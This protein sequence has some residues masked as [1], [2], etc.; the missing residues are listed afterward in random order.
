[1]NETETAPANKKGNMEMKEM[2]KRIRYNLLCAAVMA[3]TV[4]LAG[5]VADDFGFQSSENNESTFE[6]CISRAEA[7]TRDY[8]GTDF[9]EAEKKVASV[10]LFFY[11]NGATET[12]EAVHYC[13]VVPTMD[14]EAATSNRGKLNVSIPKEIFSGDAKTCRVYAAVNTDETKDKEKLTLGA[15]RDIKATS[16]HFVSKKLNNENDKEAVK[17]FPGFVMFTVAPDGDLVTY[18]EAENKTTGTVIVNKLA[19]K[20]DLFLGFG[21]E[22]DGSN[23]TV[24]APDPNDPSNG[25]KTWKVYDEEKDAIE[26]FIVNGVR[27]VRLGGYNG[28]DF[29][30]AA[31]YF[32]FRQDG[33]RRYAHGFKLSNADDKTTYPNVVEAPFYTY[34]NEWT[35]D[36]LEQHRTHLVLKVNWIPVNGN[37]ETDL[38]ET[39]YMVPLNVSGDSKDRI[40]SNQHYRVK[41]KINTLG[42]QHFGE[43][44]VLD[45]CSYEILPWGT[46]DIDAKL[47]ETRYLEVRQQSEELDPEGNYYTAVMNNVNQITIPYYSSHKVEIESVQI[48]YTDFNKFNT[49]GS[50]QDL[51]YHSAGSQ[52]VE[53]LEPAYFTKTQNELNDNE[54]Q[55][56]YIDDINQ[57]ITVQHYIGISNQNGNH[58][59]Y[60]TGNN[61]TNDNYIFTPYIITIILRH[62]DNGQS[63]DSKRTIKIKH[64]PPI[65]INGEVN[66]SINLTGSNAFN[67]RQDTNHDMFTHE[68]ALIY[69]Q[70]TFFG[71]A[72]VN[73]NTKIETSGTIP[74]A[75]NEKN[76]DNI[77]DNAYGGFEGMTKAGISDATTNNPIMYIISATNLDDS[78]KPYHIAD[79]RFNLSNTDLSGDRL[80][81]EEKRWQDTKSWTPVDARHIDK[82]PTS[83][84]GNQLEYYYPTNEGLAEENMW[85]IAPKFRIGSSFGTQ[86][87]GWFNTASTISRVDARRRCASY[88]EYGYPAGRWR[89]PT[90]GEIQFVMALSRKGVIPKL[91]ETGS[92]YIY[93]TAQGGYYFDGE[94]NATVDNSNVYVRCVYDDWYW[95]NHLETTTE[96]YNKGYVFIWGDRERNNPQE[97]PN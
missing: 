32:D 41:V 40:V 19:A 29:L 15:L 66:T 10:D 96:M 71:F 18:D 62:T 2:M 56:A 61:S 83:N 7:G 24:T 74:K 82:N 49:T 39:Y 73:D 79:P 57:K 84:S 80:F 6:L 60:V 11:P 55:C 53:F 27:S 36:V 68:I 67:D 17:G 86:K 38:L 44:L 34:P 47:R 52:N 33:L 48:E 21:A 4:G 63:A 59:D 46:K 9:T 1:M 97:Q 22:G 75:Y 8:S 31:D 70:M 35:T 58:Y 3:A 95:D 12:T 50:N 13:R 76:Y 26:V 87:G 85:A 30:D 65:Y 78:W 77:R 64:Y 81:E 93:A 72:R 37:V 45:N 69:R 16:D 91:F 5:C 28:L 23:F 92:K 90:L 94:G 51:V 88:T 25:N 20:I 42:G 54:W 43:P 89:L 14:S